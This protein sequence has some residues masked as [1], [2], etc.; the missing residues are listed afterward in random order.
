V[1][2]V[3]AVMLTSGTIV[4]LPVPQRRAGTGSL[5]SWLR[6]AAIAPLLSTLRTTGAASPSR[7][8]RSKCCITNT[9]MGRP[10]KIPAERLSHYVQARVN[11]HQWNWLEYRAVEFHEGDLSKAIRECIGW[12][13]TAVAIFNAADP[14]AKLDEYLDPSRTQEFGDYELVMDAEPDDNAA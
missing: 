3:R 2:I 14:H 4:R 1:D 12:S 7:L 13:Q 8:T 5:S 10:R 9:P 11:D 6:R